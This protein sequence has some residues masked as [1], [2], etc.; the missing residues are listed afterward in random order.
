MAGKMSDHQREAISLAKRGKPGR[1]P[2]REERKNLSLAL[3]GNKNRLGKRLRPST[4]AI[5]DID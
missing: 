5:P 3:L 2:T 4:Y 1:K